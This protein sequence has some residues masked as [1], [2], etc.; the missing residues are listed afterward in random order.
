MFGYRDLR[1]GKFVARSNYSFKIEA[2]CD[3]KRYTNIFLTSISK[4]YITFRFSHPS[5]QVT[6]EDRKRSSKV[7]LPDN[8]DRLKE[9]NTYISG[10]L[11]RPVYADIPDKQFKAYFQK[12]LVEHIQGKDINKV[13]IS[14]T[15]L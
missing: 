1:N 2:F 4:S 15:G 13:I 12:Q 10:V 3:G 11:K 14:Y 7:L 6:V 9:I 8:L 5:W